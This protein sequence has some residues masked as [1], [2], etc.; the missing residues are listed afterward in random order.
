MGVSTSYQRL[1]ARCLMQE[2]D[3]STQQIGTQHAPVLKAAGL[4]ARG[5]EDVDAWLRGLTRRQCSDLN[6]ALAR[7]KA[8][9]SR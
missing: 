8:D 9:R 5:G 3:L 2:L 7:A 1:Y 4:Q 6:N